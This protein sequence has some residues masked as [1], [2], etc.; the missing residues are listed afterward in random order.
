MQSIGIEPNMINECK[1]DS[2]VIDDEEGENY[3]LKT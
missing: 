1:K 3:I 2:F